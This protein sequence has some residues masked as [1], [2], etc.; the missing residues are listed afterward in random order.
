M[1]IA[2]AVCIKNATIIPR[3]SILR[4]K[5]SR[6][7]RISK[8]PICAASRTPYSRRN[9]TMF[10]ST[11]RTTRSAFAPARTARRGTVNLPWRCTNVGATVKCSGDL[12]SSPS[13]APAGSMTATCQKIRRAPPST[14]RPGRRSRLSRIRRQRRW[15]ASWRCRGAFHRCRAKTTAP[16]AGPRCRRQSICACRRA[17]LDPLRCPKATAGTRSPLRM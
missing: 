8:T 5:I 13:K 12:Q 10:F 1:Y 11:A 6:G 2:S 16:F 14:R 4:A 9:P 17:L 3:V 7:R 15:S